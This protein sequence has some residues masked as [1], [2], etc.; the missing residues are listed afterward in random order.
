[1]KE[2]SCS[3]PAGTFRHES[4][5]DDIRDYPK[6]EISVVDFEPE[7]VSPLAAQPL[8]RRPYA[9]LLGTYSTYV[10]A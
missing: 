9:D 5:R 6:L 10:M 3:K 1:L 2:F 7:V 8:L 4:D